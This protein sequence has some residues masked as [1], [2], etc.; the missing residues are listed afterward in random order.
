MKTTASVENNDTILSQAEAKRLAD[1]YL[2][3][4]QE[5]RKLAGMEPIQ[6]RNVERNPSRLKPLAIDARGTGKR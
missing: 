5:Y 4:A 3:L 2:A 1:L 6:T